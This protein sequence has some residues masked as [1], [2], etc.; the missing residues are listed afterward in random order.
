MSTIST[1]W[2]LDFVWPSALEWRMLVFVGL[3]AVLA[4]LLMNQA[5]GLVAAAVPAWNAARVSHAHAYASALA[6]VGDLVLPRITDDGTHVYHLFTV[7]S[8]HRDALR[9]HLA[10]PIMAFDEDPLE[11]RSRQKFHSTREGA[12]GRSGESA[13]GGCGCQ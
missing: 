2:P 11:A 4:Q 5:L 1:S 3:L 10:D 8:A 6:G 7:R 9:A 13:G 12:A